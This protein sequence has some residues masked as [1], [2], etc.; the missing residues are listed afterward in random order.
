MNNKS[1]LYV[2]FSPYENTGN[3]LD[4]LKEN[5]DLVILFTFDFYKLGNSKEVNKIVIYSY[6][7]TLNTY[8]LFSLPI[9]NRLVFFL[10]PI[11]S[12]LILAQLMW[13]VPRMVSYYGG[14]DYYFTVNAFTAWIGIWLR[15]FGVVDK[16]VFWVWD[17]YPPEHRVFIVRLMRKVYGY[18]DRQAAFSDRLVFLTKRLAK[19]RGYNKFNTVS[20]GVN[21]RKKMGRVVGKGVRL[22]FLG[23]IKKSQGLDMVLNSAVKLCEMFPGIS[24]E[25]IGSGP[26]ELY[27]KNRS[28][29]LPIRVIFLGYLREDD[30]QKKI[31]QCHIG[32]ATYM[33]EEG[34]VS[35]FGDP[36]KIKSYLGCGLPVIATDVFEFSTQLTRNGAGEIVNYGDSKGFT[37]AV[38]RIVD[39][40]SRYRHNVIRMAKRYNYKNLYVKMFV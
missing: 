39:N 33:P 8:H 38:K 35:Y 17:F 32:L 37:L 16:T 11:R 1:I 6:G 28:I 14:I 29:H 3:I 22:V 10:L 25:V 24:L 2:N 9:H 5:F 18:F 30:L 23:V 27:F 36:S 4:F 15:R 31:A 26:D 12:L 13:W 40:Y 19:L 34:N 7:K 21:P 20:I